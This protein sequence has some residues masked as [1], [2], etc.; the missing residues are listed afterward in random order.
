MG[1]AAKISIDLDAHTAALK[2]GFAEARGEIQKLGAGMSGSVAAGMAK[3]HLALTA[4]QGA[5]ATVSGAIGAV[6]A[7]MEAMNATSKLADRL[8]T[9]ADSLEILRYAA[10]QTGGT[11]ENLTGAVQD[12]NKNLAEAVRGSDT[13]AT[14][15]EKLGLDAAALQTMDLTQQL[16]LLAD[17]F[18]NVATTSE[19]MLIAEALFG[20][21]GR[22]MLNIIEDGSDGLNRFAAEAADLGLLMGDSREKVEAAS[23]AIAKMKSAWG[24]LVNQ[25]AVAVAPALAA[26]AE[27]MATVVS[28]FNRLFGMG[29]TPPVFSS[30]ETTAG[31]ALKATRAEMAAAEEQR[32]K[33]EDEAAKAMETFAA[34][35]AAI[36][37]TLRTPFEIF[38]DHLRD[39]D[40]LLARGAISAETW[41]RGAAKAKEDLA[42]TFGEPQ[43]YQTQGIGAVTRNSMA[44]YSATQAAQRQREDDARRHAEHM[45]RLARI[46]AAVADAGITLA[47]MTI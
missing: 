15:M 14:A 5:L 6:T 35:G 18:Q 13:Q 21:A 47:P 36:T 3:F 7:S 46:E 34:R 37:E 19:K 41:R 29:G 27:G 30:I 20:G 10:E 9:D 25:V 38:R 11:F 16:G 2:Q 45:S 22:E 33:A 8:N 42:K 31:A 28:W 39:L 40:E 12:W 43:Q 1:N 23:A 26:I 44:A 17:G 24:A 4:V 32:K